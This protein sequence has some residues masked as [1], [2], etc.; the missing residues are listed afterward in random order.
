MKGLLLTVCLI[1][2]LAPDALAQPMPAPRFVVGDSWTYTDGRQI[3]VVKVEDGGAVMTGAFAVCPACV[4]H[5]DRNLAIRKVTDADGK[6][7]EAARLDFLALGPD[8]KFY[9]FPLDVKKTWTFSAEGLLRGRPHRFEV[10]VAV[11]AL[12][13]VTTKAGTFKAFKMERTWSF[14]QDGQANRFTDILWFAPKAKFPVKF[15]SSRAGV[16]PGELSAYA[17]K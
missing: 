13:D 4:V 6:P 2:A 11:T 17:V 15:H 14:T 5:Y 3:K 7:V 12:E 10:A 1:A 9:A 8:W 16:K